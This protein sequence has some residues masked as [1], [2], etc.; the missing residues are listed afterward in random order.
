MISRKKLSAFILNIIIISMIISITSVFMS[1]GNTLKF[2][3]D[4]VTGN[5]I[6]ETNGRYYIYC[7]GYLR[8]ASILNGVYAKGDRGEK[9]YEVD[10][11]DPAEWLSED[12]TA[13]AAPFL[14]REQSVE[15]PV[16]ADFETKIIHI[17]ITEE[18]TLAVGA[19]Q[20]KADIDIIANDFLNNEEVPVPEFI[21]DV[22]TFN[23]ESDKYKGIYY[24]LEYY[25][26][27]KND[28]YLY[29]RWT[30]RCVKCGIKLFTGNGADIPEEGEL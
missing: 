16:F 17:T 27:E 12:I 19:I 24:I 1:C 7:K 18:I 10:G 26:D 25:V 8:A 9:L 13:F 22:F 23:F 28:G 4:G 2:K 21:T 14:F 15:E 11:L 6:D 29:D 20:D 30:K 5:L 3:N